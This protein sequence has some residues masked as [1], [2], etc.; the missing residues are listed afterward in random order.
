M[1]I[2]NTTNIYDRIIYGNANTNNFYFFDGKEEFL[3]SH[4]S[5]IKVLGYLS[6]VPPHFHVC[7]HSAIW[8]DVT[9]VIDKLQD[10]DKLPEGQYIVCYF[11]ADENL[12]LLQLVDYNISKQQIIENVLNQKYFEGAD[13]YFMENLEVAA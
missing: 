5:D 6:E 1:D 11:K 3:S 12:D 13:Y 10:E 7:K 4:L 2:T 9:G 8:E